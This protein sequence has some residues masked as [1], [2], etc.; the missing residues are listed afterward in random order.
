MKELNIVERSR[1][2]T[3]NIHDHSIR[4]HSQLESNFVL[5][6]VPAEEDGF[7]R[8]SGL[9]NVYTCP[10]YKAEH[11]FT[12]E[13]ERGDIG[14]LSMRSYCILDRG[15]EDMERWFPTL[16]GIPNMVFSLF[17]EP[18]ENVLEYDAQCC[19]RTTKHRAHILKRHATSKLEEK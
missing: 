19:H 8:T 7:N 3:G 16:E 14:F 11:S 1:N 18:E 4:G 12:E 13:V 10:I 2:R 9:T 6:V 15:R 17:V 5:S